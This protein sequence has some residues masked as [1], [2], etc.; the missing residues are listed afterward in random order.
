MCLPAGFARSRRGFTLVELLVV[1]AIIGVL[2]G[3][4]LPAVQA[5]RESAR[6][7]S[8]RN[9]LKQLG[10]G[11]HSFLSAKTFFPSNNYAPNAGTTWWSWER[12]SAHWQLL[13]Y[14]EQAPLAAQFVIG[15][16]SAPGAF[17]G[18][19]METLSK[20][21]V[22]TFVCPSAEAGDLTWG[23]NNYGWS[24]G[25]ST[26]ATGNANRT[27]ANGFIH[28]EERGTGTNNPTARTEPNNSWPGRT[29]SD[30]RDGMTNVLM[31]SELLTGTGQN[32]VDPYQPLRNV[33]LV[34]AAGILNGTATDINFPT[35]AELQ[36]AGTSALGAANGWRGNNGQRWAVYQ[37]SQTL[38]NTAAP[39]NWEYPSVGN[40]TPGIAIDHGWGVI[41]PRSNHG[42]YVNAMFCDGS[43]RPVADNIDILTFQRM[44]H[45][46]D[47]ATI[48]KE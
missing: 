36:T 37:Q 3:L 41:P 38:L 1:I 22:S 44:G 13:P 11:M 7:N 16:T 19:A 15:G 39:P 12:L 28:A 2:V 20:S 23:G 30:I 5:A 31:A 17:G 24:T 46:R 18:S 43:I 10:T 33:S 48:P 21:K 9:N 34:A 29:P 25:S 42:G 40:G 14:V 35:A 47:G 4:L 26:H 45:R 27:T 8:C 32:A 6:A